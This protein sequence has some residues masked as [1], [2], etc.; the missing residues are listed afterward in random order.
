MLAGD[1]EKEENP[2]YP[3]KKRMFPHDL[4]SKELIRVIANM[5]RLSIKN[6][7]ATNRSGFVLILNIPINLFI[8]LCRFRR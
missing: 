7:T 8:F 2:K 6:Q 1:T 3:Q 5:V 4:L